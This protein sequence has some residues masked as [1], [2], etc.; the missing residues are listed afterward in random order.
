METTASTILMEIE[1]EIIITTIMDTILSTSA[2]MTIMA[3]FNFI[4]LKGVTNMLLSVMMTIST[5]LN[6]S[7]GATGKNHACSKL[8]AMEMSRVM[9][10]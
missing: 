10:Q 7:T 2:A 5:A 4:K 6:L 1:V 3:Q 9:K 8:S